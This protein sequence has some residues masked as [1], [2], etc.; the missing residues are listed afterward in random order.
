MAAYT[1]SWR[2]RRAGL[3]LGLGLLAGEQDRP[4]PAR[5]LA[6]DRVGG[7]A[8]LAPANAGPLGRGDRL[9]AVLDQDELF[10]ADEIRAAVVAIGA[11]G[12]H[13][14]NVDLVQERVLERQ[15]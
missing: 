14:L 12:D 4:A 15:F 6:G 9:A 2:A 1:G 11:F 8:I 7:V 13:D 10:L 5:P 3:E